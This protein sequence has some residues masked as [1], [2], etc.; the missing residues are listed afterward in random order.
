MERYTNCPSEHIH[1]TDKSKRRR[2]EIQL[3]KLEKAMTQK[4][5]G[6]AALPSTG[7]HFTAASQP[8]ATCL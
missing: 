4:T 5:R 6:A 1:K 8:P 2:E 3:Q 7:P